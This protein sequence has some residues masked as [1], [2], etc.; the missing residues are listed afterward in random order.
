MS[1]ASA[2]RYNSAPSIRVTPRGLIN[3]N[4]QSVDRAH[5]IQALP[6]QEQAN[7]ISRWLRPTIELAAVE[8]EE[9]YGRPDIQRSVALERLCAMG[10]FLLSAELHDQV[11][12]QIESENATL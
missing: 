8:V 5:A 4:R 7:A 10:G 3:P 1:V 9:Y 12:D 11:M 6:S 2:E